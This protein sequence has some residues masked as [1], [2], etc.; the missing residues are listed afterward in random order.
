[1][2]VDEIRQHCWAR[3]REAFGTSYIQLSTSITIPAL[4]AGLEL[5]VR[6]CSVLG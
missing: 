1:M 5:D 4:S 6:G 2:T 3:A